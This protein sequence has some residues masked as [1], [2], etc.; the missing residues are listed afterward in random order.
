MGLFI[1][2]FGSGIKKNMQEIKLDPQSQIITVEGTQAKEFSL[3]LIL[4]CYFFNSIC[5]NIKVL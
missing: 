5:L 1:T 4:N 3:A 2:V